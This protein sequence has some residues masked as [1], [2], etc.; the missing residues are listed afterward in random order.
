[1]TEHWKHKEQS[2]HKRGYGTAWD[3][4]RKVILARDNHLCQACLARGLTTPGNHVD[5]ILSKAKGGTDD[6]ANLRTLCKPCHSRKSNEERG[7]RV[8]KGFSE[9]GWP[10]DWV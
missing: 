6:T 3:K 2:R 7:F 9:D 10:E 4:L 8:R 1:M 5:H